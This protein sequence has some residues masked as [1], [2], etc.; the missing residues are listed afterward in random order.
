M[1][2]YH[3][4]AKPLDWLAQLCQ[5]LCDDALHCIAKLL[6]TERIHE[7]LLHVLSQL[8]L[9]EN[10]EEQEGYTWPRGKKEDVN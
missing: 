4:K 2:V 9:T 6:F 3:M 7:V 8:I 10:Y 1:S 5:L